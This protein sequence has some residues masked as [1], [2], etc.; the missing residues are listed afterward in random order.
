MNLSKMTASATK[1]TALLKAL[2]NKHRL[3]I[4]C[5]LSDSEKSVGELEELLDMRQPHLSQH[6]A[7]L[8][9]DGLVKT[10]RDS[11]TIYYAIESRAAA[12]VIGLLYDLYCAP[13]RAGRA[14]GRPKGRNGAAA[15]RARSRAAATA[16][17]A[18][19]KRRRARRQPPSSTP[20]RTSM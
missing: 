3:I 20:M 1:A 8:R 18:D 5:Y 10:R 14:A 11:R 9:H 6:L 19:A 2:A 4:L 7:R 13:A 12:R 16:S 17:R 15:N